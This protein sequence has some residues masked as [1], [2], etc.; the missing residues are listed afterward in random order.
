MENS[1]TRAVDW[2]G[3]GVLIFEMLV[4]EVSLL[5]LCLWNM[6][7]GGGGFHYLRSSWDDFYP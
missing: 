3:M 4:G 1:Y 6:L 2:W 5:I 7:G